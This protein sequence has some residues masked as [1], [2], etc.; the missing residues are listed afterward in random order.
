MLLHISSIK[1][2]S[3]RSA[4]ALFFYLS[5]LL[6]FL[7][8]VSVTERP[9]IVDDHFLVKAYYSLSLFVVGGIDLGTPVGGPQFGRVLLWVAYFG[10]PILAASTLIETFFR[11]IARENWQLR[12]IKNHIVLYQNSVAIALCCLYRQWRLL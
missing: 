6:A 7:V 3:W 12:H 5:S 10:A 4:L 2:L 9:S 8:G 11:A 1:R